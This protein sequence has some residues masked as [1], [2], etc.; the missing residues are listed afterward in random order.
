MRGTTSSL[1]S[2]LSKFDQNE[3]A[4]T[5]RIAIKSTEDSQAEDVTKDQLSLYTLGYQQL[6]GNNADRIQILN[7]DDQGKSTNDPVDSTLIATIK[8]KIDAVAGDIREN[9]FACTHDHSRQS[10]YDDHAWPT[11]GEHTD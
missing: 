8:A 11:K 2:L 9:R 5:S 3:C 7:L 1:T 4:K 6:T 10:A